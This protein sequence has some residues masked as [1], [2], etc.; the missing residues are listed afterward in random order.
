MDD[1]RVSSESINLK[2]T[3]APIRL[4][5]EVVYLIPKYHGFSY[6]DN[7][8]SHDVLTDT[9]IENDLRTVCT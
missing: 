4:Y 8:L 6:I 3:Q 1:Y 5:L 9:N 2:V 7:T